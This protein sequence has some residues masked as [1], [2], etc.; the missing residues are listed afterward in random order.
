MLITNE[1]INPAKWLP[2]SYFLPETIEIKIICIKIQKGLWSITWTMRLQHRWTGWYDC[3]LAWGM[4][5]FELELWTHPET[6]V[7]S[8]VRYN[9]YL[10][11]IKNH[12]LNVLWSPFES[13]MI[14]PSCLW[15]P[16][17]SKKPILTKW[18]EE[19]GIHN[20]KSISQPTGFHKSKQKIH[21]KCV[22][23]HV[24]V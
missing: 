11:Q 16:A 5:G 4:D 2:S 14:P 10:K 9:F 1:H 21:Y 19:R 6:P 12:D 3:G 24:C 20:Q 17:F 18:G 13:F 15:T 8:S 22:C 23:V 7:G